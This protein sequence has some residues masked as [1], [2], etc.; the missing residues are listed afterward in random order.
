MTNVRTKQIVLFLGDVCLLYA[1]LF[2]TLLAR[3]GIITPELIDAH[4]IPFSLIFI[5][6]IAIFYISGF[7]DVAGIDNIYNVIERISVSIFFSALLSVA[8]FYAVPF[9]GITPKTNLL[10]FALLFFVLE[11]A[12][13]LSF[14][15]LSKSPQRHVLIIGEGKDVDIFTN[16]LTH[17]PHL[18]FKIAFQ[19]KD[20][21]SPQMP[22]FE[23]IISDYHITTIVIKQKLSQSKEILEKILV[24]LSKGIEVVDLFTAYETI[25]KQVP[26]SE[27]EEFWV[28]TNLS[29][30][31]K[32]YEAAKRP[33]ELVLALV[34]FIVLLPLLALIWILV[35]LTSKGP[36]IYSQVRIGK[37][38]SRFR[39]YKFRTMIQ[40]AEQNGPQWSS[41]HD[42]RVTTM[43]KFLRFTHLDELPQLINIIKGNLSFV[44][45]RPERPEFVKDLRKEIPYYELRHLIRPGVT[46]WAQINFR[47]GSSIEDAQQKLR[48]DVYYIKHRSLILDFLIILKTAKMFVFNHE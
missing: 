2:F 44:G 35:K 32:A 18:G 25:L 16:F 34:L 40:G 21:S 8:L 6:W 17:A 45:P 23:K 7:Y 42:E 31:R 28:L 19:I 13:R 26:T 43:G 5:L 41:V 9:F 33:I 39:I 24:Y 22:P 30:N 38:E 46:G 10:I 20:V 47:Y 12:W 36:G 37:N 48:Y 29:Q 3:Y 27:I 4:L 15:S 11:G 1:A 14:R